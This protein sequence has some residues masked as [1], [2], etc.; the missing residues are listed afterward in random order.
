MSWLLR[1][2]HQ[3]ALWHDGAV[4]GAHPAELQGSSLHA[5]TSAVSLEC[6]AHVDASLPQLTLELALGLESCLTGSLLAPSSPGL[7]FSELSLSSPD[8]FFVAPQTFICVEA[9]KLF[10]YGTLPC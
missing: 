6:H 1:T 2:G 10:L 9:K 4:P 5:G 7:S 8:A 3:A